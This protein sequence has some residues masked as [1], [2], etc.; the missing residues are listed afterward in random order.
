MTEILKSF[1]ARPHS[2]NR[3][4]EPVLQ[5]VASPA[6]WCDIN[7][8][9]RMHSSR[10]VF[11]LD[12]QLQATD[13][14]IALRGPSGIGKTMI[15]RAIAGLVTPDAGR[16]AVQDHTLYDSEARI[17]LPAQQR[18][19]GFMFQDY[20]LLPHL[21]AL[22][23][24]G[25]GLRRGMWG[26]LSREHKE[27]AMHWLERFHLAHVAHQHPH[28][29]SGGQRQRLALARL[30]ILKPR[31]LLLD[32]PFAALDPEL[33]QAM[34]QEVDGLLQTLDIPLLMVT[35]DEEDRAMLQATEIRIGQVNGRTIHLDESIT[36]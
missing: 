4:M 25:F 33:R 23:N 28:T 13:R 18:R 1:A 32:E 9:K 17:D 8:R 14:R 12:V 11:E 6:T 29:L 34:R 21:T 36:Q 20:A 5:S 19:V 16:I 3:D 27:E 30:A 22:G 35:H 26:F 15:L 7:V 2:E 10:R 31:A 24:V